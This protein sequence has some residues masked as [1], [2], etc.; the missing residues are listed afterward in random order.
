MT[1]KVVHLVR[2]IGEHI[3]IIRRR[4]SPIAAVLRRGIPRT[5]HTCILEVL[6]NISVGR[7]QIDAG[8]CCWHTI[9][10][11]YVILICDS[12]HKPKFWYKLKRYIAAIAILQDII[13]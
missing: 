1:F 10:L 2:N 13:L 11:G 7:E 3:V 6:V 8:S 12:I 4:A 9:T 5:G